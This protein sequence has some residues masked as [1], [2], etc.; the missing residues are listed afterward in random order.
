MAIKRAIEVLLILLMCSMVMKKYLVGS[1]DNIV[2]VEAYSPEE[3]WAKSAT[4]KRSAV[5]IKRLR[6]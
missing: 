5:R 3:A 2:Y 6:W 4:G 1:Y